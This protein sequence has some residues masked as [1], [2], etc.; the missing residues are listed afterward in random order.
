M[1][2]LQ[3][4]PT[5]VFHIVLRLGGKRYKRSLHTKVESK[6]I[7]RRDEIQE[8]VDL[9]R[10][11]KIKI[12]EGTAAI[13]FVL[14]DEDAP[15]SNQADKAVVE[16][17]DKVPYS[18]TPLVSVFERFFDAIPPGNVEDETLRMMHIHKRHLLRILS[19]KLDFAKLTGEQLQSYVSKRAKEKTQYFIQ[20]S[21]GKKSRRSVGASTIRKE[22]TTLGAAW[23]WA[24]TVPLV[25]TEFPKQGL[26]FP[27]TDE[28]PPFQTWQEIERQIALGKL[29]ACEADELWECLFLRTNEITDLAI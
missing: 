10:R 25:T 8:T 3:Q 6:A 2:S 15:A 12:P 19:P 5:G 1:A 22:I 29:N 21:G 23:K 28:K 11:G 7:S 27:K 26:R 9:L 4:E 16:S 14:H 13:D 18:P 17:P 20:Q 24:K